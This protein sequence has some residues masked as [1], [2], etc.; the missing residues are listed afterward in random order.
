MLSQTYK[1]SVEG[2]Y[3]VKVAA[4]T[5]IAVKDST[6]ET[7]RKELQTELKSAKKTKQQIRKGHVGC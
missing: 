7:A 1:A 5:E 2:E 6:L 4:S 3:Y